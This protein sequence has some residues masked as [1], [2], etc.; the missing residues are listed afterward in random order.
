MQS[1]VII[2]VVIA[3]VVEFTVMDRE[4]GLQAED[5]IAALPDERA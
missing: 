3:I 2:G 1:Q 4:K 5:V